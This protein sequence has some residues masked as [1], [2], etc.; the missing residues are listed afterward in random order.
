MD[1]NNRVG[2]R[3]IIIDIGDIIRGLDVVFKNADFFEYDLDELLAWAL[4]LL[5]FKDTSM[6]NG[7]K[8]LTF[9]PHANVDH[10]VYM[11]FLNKLHRLLIINNCY[12]ANG[13]LNVSQ[14]KL[15]RSESLMLNFEYVI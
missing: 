8:S 10:K 13:V 15:I 12:G 11:T 1:Y 4:K 5:Q 9:Y 7:E 14:F 3:A 2:S 6:S